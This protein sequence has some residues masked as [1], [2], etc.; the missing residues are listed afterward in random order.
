MKRF[1]LISFLVCALGP[2]IRPALAQQEETVNVNFR[3]FCWDRVDDNI[4]YYRDGSKEVRVR[5]PWMKRTEELHYQGQPVLQFY[6]K[7]KNTEGQWEKVPVAKVDFS[8]PGIDSPLILFYEMKGAGSEKFGARVLNDDKENFPFGSYRVVNLTPANIRG[9]IGNDLFTLQPGETATVTPKKLISNDRNVV[10]QMQ[11]PVNGQYKTVSESVWTHH[12]DGRT[13][14]FLIE[15]GDKSRE[16][17]KI[18]VISEFATDVPPPESLE[19]RR[20][21]VS[22]EDQS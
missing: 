14:C 19:L 16:Y 17:F 4:I 2:G 20:M 9:H 21:D 3:A 11:A 15:S 12:K 10:V 6:Q 18:N 13:M 5:L 1:L 8:Q 22:E 7:H